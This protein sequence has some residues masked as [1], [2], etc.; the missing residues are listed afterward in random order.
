MSALQIHWKEQWSRSQVSS[1]E[2]ADWLGTILDTKVS[3]GEK[4]LMHVP[5]IYGLMAE[6]CVIMRHWCYKN[7]RSVAH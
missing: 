1:L 6:A 3:R 4:S 7:E 5:D 2:E